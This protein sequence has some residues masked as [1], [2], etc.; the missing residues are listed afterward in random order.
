MRDDNVPLLEKDEVA[1]STGEESLDTQANK[2]TK[3]GK[4]RYQK[5]GDAIIYPKSSSK[6]KYGTFQEEAAP[7]V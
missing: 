7:K 2:G 1:N 3:A 6:D 4:V 5:N